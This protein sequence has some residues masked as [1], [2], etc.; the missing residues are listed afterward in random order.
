MPIKQGFDG[1]HIFPLTAQVSAQPEVYIVI[2]DQNRHTQQLL[3][4]LFPTATIQQEVRDWQGR[5]YARFYE[6]PA[7][8][9]PQHPPQYPRAISLGDGIALLG[10]DL[11]PA[12]LHPG[13]NLYVQ[14]HWLVK[15]APTL[16]WIVFTHVL[17]KDATGKVSVVAKAA[18]QPGKNSL[19]TTRWQKGWRILDEYKIK[20]PATLRP[21]AYNIA[22]G[23]YQ[24]NGAHL[25]PEGSGMLLG[26]VKIE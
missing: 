9:V 12:A 14:F 22:M 11:Q 16:N 13:D 24:A 4:E 6:R 15:S 2:A 26:Q 25:P 7:G 21:G 8:A 10:Y 19:P 17:A 20:L 23:L 18:S 1:R 5:V 3:P